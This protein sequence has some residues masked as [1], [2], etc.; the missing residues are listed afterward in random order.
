MWRWSY[1]KNRKYQEEVALGSRRKSVGSMQLKMQ[2]KLTYQDRCY[3]AI[4]QC[5][6]FSPAH[7]LFRTFREDSHLQ[8]MNTVD[9][10]NDVKTLTINHLKAHVNAEWNA[11]FK[12]SKR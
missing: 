4:A 6:M 5:F 11:F 9:G 8:M 1:S 2:S 12:A 3:S 7:P 10:L